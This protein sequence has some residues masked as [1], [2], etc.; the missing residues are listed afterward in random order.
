MQ[1]VQY[2]LGG[3]HRLGVL[4]MSQVVPWPTIT[5]AQRLHRSMQRID[6]HSNATL[7]LHERLQ[8]AEAPDRHGQPIGLRSLLERLSEERPILLAQ[9]RRTSPP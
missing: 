2:P 5:I 9:F 1:P 4:A 6:T 8:V 3:S 7:T